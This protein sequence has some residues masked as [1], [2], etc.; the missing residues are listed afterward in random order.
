[1]KTSRLISIISTVILAIAALVLKFGMKDYSKSRQREIVREYVNQ[2]KQFN[3]IIEKYNADEPLSTDEYSALS[4]FVISVLNNERKKLDDCST[5]EELEA[6]TSENFEDRFY[7]CWTMLVNAPNGAIAEE[8][9]VLSASQDLWLL[10]IEK[11]IKFNP[12]LKE[13]YEE[14]YNELKQAT[15]LKEFNNL[16]LVDWEIQ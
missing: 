7:D 15:S 12:I 9:D 10:L 13:E 2:K 6:W 4:K 1:M 14:Y 3:N 11:Y 5:Y 8:A 16:E